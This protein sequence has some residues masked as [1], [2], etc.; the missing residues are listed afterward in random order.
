MPRFR[1]LALVLATVLMTPFL[2]LQVSAQAPGDRVRLNATH[3]DGVPV[4]PA[5]G[6]NSYVRWANGTIANVLAVDPPTGWIQI[7]SAGKRG[8]AT[9]R[10]LTVLPPDP[11]PDDSDDGPELLTY[12]IAA[13]NLEHFHDGATRGF[14]ENGNGGPSYGTRSAADLTQI[15]DI[16][17]TDLRARILILSEINGQAGLTT[18]V[19]MDRLIAATGSTWQY[20]LTRA[21]NAQRIAIMF[22][23]AAARLGICEEI[24][25]AEERV[26]NSDIFARDPLACSFT[27]LDAA[28]AA[29]NDL[30]VMGVHLASGQDKVTNHNRAMTVLRQRLAGLFSGTPFA[31]AERDVI[32]GGDFNANRYDNRIEDFWTDFDPMGFRFQTLSPAEDEDYP[33]SRLAGV[34]LFPRSKIDYLM[35][36]TRTG[37]I[38]DELVQL[39][40]E[41]HTHLIGEDDFDDFREHVSDHLPVSVRVRVVPDDD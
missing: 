4:H 33:A 23:T 41:V 18:S 10:Y 3:Q 30:V 8:W 29:R 1:L 19:E 36:S 28:G 16:I 7:E 35:G 20:R 37:G 21:G 26:Q 6:D 22:D 40:A 2:W 13:W 27:L 17:R 24:T 38:S 9:R 34:P 12:G 39:T 31:T 5:A 14:P 25:V 32:I 11:D 15:A